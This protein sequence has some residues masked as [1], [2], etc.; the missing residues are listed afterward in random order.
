MARFV[1]AHERSVGVTQNEG[2]EGDPMIRTALPADLPQLQ[3]VFRAA[4][5]SNVGDAPRLLAHP[6]FLVFTGDGIAGGWTRLA[7]SGPAD[8]CTVLGFVTAVPGSDREL[9]LDDLFVDPQFQ[10]RGVARELISDTV[11]SARAGR[12]RRLSVIANPHASAVYSAVGFLGGDQVT[13][14]LGE[15]LRM[16]LEIT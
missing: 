7:E 5:L 11:E 4:S 8:M 16:H 1:D 10:R 6:E 15:G 9:E 14:A 12:Y 2:A 13:T 3:R